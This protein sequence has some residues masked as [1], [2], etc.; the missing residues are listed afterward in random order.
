MV[1]NSFSLKSDHFGI[2]TN[3]PHGNEWHGTILKSDHFGI[4]TWLDGSQGTP[5]D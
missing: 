5:E 4:E 3:P 2:E 1:N